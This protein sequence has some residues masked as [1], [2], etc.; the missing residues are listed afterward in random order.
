MADGFQQGRAGAG[1]GEMLDG[2]VIQPAHVRRRMLGLDVVG[3]VR[4]QA[5]AQ[6]DVI[7]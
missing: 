7:A 6:I 2:L 4:C 1:A 5:S 3:C